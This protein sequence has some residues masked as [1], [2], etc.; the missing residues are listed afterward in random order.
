MT[1]RGRGSMD[2]YSQRLAA[3]LDVPVLTSDIYQRSARRFGVSL[4]SPTA[5]RLAYADLAFVRRLRRLET[6]V[7]VPNHHLARYAKLANR[8]YVVTVHDLIRCLDRHRSHP[9][10]SRPNARDRL[11]LAADW[12]G[13]R[14]AAGV[15]A[16]SETTRRELIEHVGLPEERVALAPN[17]I[18]HST[19]QPSNRRPF[20]FRYVLFVGSEQPRKNLPALLEAMATLA[21]RPGTDD[22]RLVKVGR[23]GGQRYRADTVARIREL[24][25]GGHVVLTEWLPDEDLAAAYSGA[26]CFVTPSLY[27]GFGLPSVEAMACGCPVITSSRGAMGEVAGDA[28]LLLDDCEPGTLAAAISNVVC[29]GRLRSGLAAAGIRRAREFTWERTAAATRAA[30]RQFAERLAEP[31]RARRRR[32]LGRRS[33]APALESPV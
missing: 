30:Y 7:H 24:G 16:V 5:V 8:P 22:L 4:L 25:L 33:D 20:G 14:A 28:A 32:R 6:P 10:I 27:E 26:E 13:I 18:D 29:D 21:R 17:G 11:L 31:D 2:L 19:F 9:L 3:R 12:S 23:A 1:T 15:I